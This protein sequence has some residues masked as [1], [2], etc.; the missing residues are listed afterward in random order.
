MEATI[1]FGQTLSNFE[2]LKK[3]N[4]ED[5]KSYEQLHTIFSNM[6]IPFCTL[7]LKK[8]M[9]LYRA[10][11]NKENETFRA[12]DQISYIKDTSL[13][14]DFGRANEP[15]QS[16]FY[17]SHKSETAIFEAS[18]LFNRDKF[19]VGNERLTLGKWYVK[20]NVELLGII[21]D[22]QAMKNDPCL[23]NLYSK[24]RNQPFP[25]DMSKIIEY[26]SKEFSKNVNDEKYQYKISCAYFNYAIKRSDSG[27]QGVVYPTVEYEF[28]D[29]NVALLPKAVDDCLILEMVAEYEVNTKSMT[30]VQVSLADINYFEPKLIKI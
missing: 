20:K 1:D 2:I 24:Y 14:T 16:I 3:T 19:N 15:G 25:K 10:R 30:I 17:G 23:M 8:G 11:R 22:E 4:L 5:S 12:K 9:Y 26:F 7:T 18:S 6:I 27:L 29:L 13:I 28:K 21:S